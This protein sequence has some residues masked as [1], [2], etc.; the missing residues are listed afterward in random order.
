VDAVKTKA[1]VS[2][3]LLTPL[4]GCIGGTSDIFGRDTSTLVGNASYEKLLSKRTS[5]EVNYIAT[6]GGNSQ[7]VGPTGV[8]FE[9]ERIT[10]GTLKNRYLLQAV[11]AN[12]TYR[13]INGERFKLTVAPGLKLSHARMDSK[14]GTFNA[15]LNRFNPGYGFKLVTSFRFTDKVPL[16]SEAAMYGREKGNGY[17]SAGV[18]FGYKPNKNTRIQ[19]G[20]SQQ[21]FGDLDANNK[22]GCSTIDVTAAECA[23]SEFEIESSGLH[24][25]VKY[26][27]D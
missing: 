18:W 9:G 14:A 13:L 25:G 6:A 3:F 10:E 21:L 11:T 19:F 20:F 24:I 1:I 12:Y 15:K 5:L 8:Q 4:S 2:I 17:A 22:D 27:T 16:F 7:T 23:D 26:F